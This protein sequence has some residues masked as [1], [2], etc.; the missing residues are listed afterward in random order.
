MTKQS[1]TPNL[2]AKTQPAS[3]AKP[4]GDVLIKTLKRDLF[5]QRKTFAGLLGVPEDSQTFT[6]WL[7]EVAHVVGLSPKLIEANRDSLMQS[8]RH[9]I[10]M[11]LSINPALGEAY[12]IPRWD[13]TLRANVVQCQRGYQ[14]LLA[15]MFRSDMI[16]SVF[17][18]VIYRD[19]VYKIY[20][21][22][23]ARIEH[24]PDVEGELRTNHFDD[25][26]IAYANVYLKGSTRPIFVYLTYADLS[27]ARAMNL[28]RDGNPSLPWREHPQ[29]MAI[30]TALARVCKM[31]PRHSKLAELHKA[32]AAES[33]GTGISLS[34][35][36]PA[37]Q[38]QGG[39]SPWGIACEAFARFDVPP[40]R[41]LSFLNIESGDDFTLDHDAVLR[42]LH[43]QIKAGD[44]SQLESD[45]DVDAGPQP[46][47]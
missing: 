13:K 22:T 1:S 44:W 47:E 45:G 41:L 46:V 42:E 29:S 21:G 18:D 36:E 27:R 17:A 35:P 4:S 33:E 20:G 28:D 43:A 10:T 7:A 9:A 37:E 23:N 11:G 16:D 32:L 12:L 24:E 8:L 39:K 6:S 3:V 40:D 2:P 14:G 31:L 26:I 25:I 34:Q 38:E 19:E 30:K 15:L 5:D